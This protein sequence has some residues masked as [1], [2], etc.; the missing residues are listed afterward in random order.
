MKDAVYV[1]LDLSL[2]SSGCLS[3]SAQGND[4][5]AS[6]RC[7]PPKLSDLRRLVYIRT[8]IAE[9]VD[10]Q[11]PVAI[12]VENY[13]F[14]ARNRAHQ[15]GELGGVVRVHLHEMGYAFTN[16]PPTS[17]KKYVLG[18]GN[19]AK[20]LMLKGVY[21]KWGYDTDSNDLA[22]G[23]GLSQLIRAYATKSDKT[24]AFKQLTAKFELVEGC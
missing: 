21:K 10:D 3:L 20:D 2:T 18:K 15:L 17:L 22:D 6:F 13:A 14:G 12:A 7:Q 5:R 9:F 24:K 16:V 19:A 8:A 23:Y 4:P 1:G 11:S